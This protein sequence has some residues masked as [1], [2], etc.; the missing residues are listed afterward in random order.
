MARAGKRARE[1]ELEWKPTRAVEEPILNGPYDEPSRHWVYE[2]DDAGVAT[3][4]ERSG[5]RPASYFSATLAR[6][7]EQL[8]SLEL[9]NRLREDVGRW[10]RSGYRGASR[11]TRELFRHWFDPS[12]TPRLFFCQREAVETIVYLLELA[13]PGR[14]AA[15]GR[16]DPRVDAP[17]L[18]RLLRGEPPGLSAATED[19]PV[20]LVDLPGDP[21]M[22]PLTRLGLR[23]ATGTG[24]TVVMAMIITWAFCNRVAEPSNTHFPNAVLV[25]APNLTVKSRL[26]VLRPEHPQSDYQR[27]DL[28]PAKYATSLQQ[29]RVLVTNW[30]AFTPRS[31]HREGDRTYRVV[32]KGEEPGDAFVKSGRLGELASRLPILV[33]NDEGHHCWR[34]KGGKI[35]DEGSREDEVE[36]AR[37]WLAGLDRINNAGLL[38]DAGGEPRRCILA[39]I[40]LSATPFYL[41][42]SGYLEGSPFPWLVTSFGLIDAIES[43]IVKIPRLPEQPRPWQRQEAADEAVRALARRWK[44]RFDAHEH[45]AAPPVMIIVCDN[46]ELADRVFQRVSGER[47][48]EVVDPQGKVK[49]A[50]FFEGSEVLAELAN[51]E[52]E[53]R[54]VRIDSRLLDKLERAEGE[55]RDE[56]ALA[57]RAI[58]DTVGKPGQPGEHIRCV[59]SVSMLTEGWDANN[60]THIL[61][62]RAFGSQLLCEQVVGRGL[63]RRSYELGADGK[64]PAEYVDVHGIPFSSIPFKGEGMADRASDGPRHQMFA[65]P[66]RA[67]LEIRMPAV[68]GYVHDIRDGGIRCDV[69]RLAPLTVHRCEAREGDH[70]AARLQQVVF[71][72][73]RRIVDDLIDGNLLARHLVFPAVSRILTEYIDRRVSFAAGV[74]R[75]ALGQEPYAS[76]LRERVRAGI[77]V[78]PTAIEGTLLPIVNRLAEYHTTAGVDGVTD[79]PVRP[80]ARCHLNAVVIRGPGDDAVIDVLE[81]AEDVEAFAPGG[82][83][84]GFGIVFDH[85]GESQRYAPD[86]IVRLRGGTHVMLEIEREGDPELAVVRRNAAQRWVVAVNNRRRY[87]A[88]AFETVYELAALRPTLRKHAAADESTPRCAGCGGAHTPGE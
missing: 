74:D 51:H 25:C 49:K 47:V 38:N 77:L 39:A 13:I 61:G 43:G 15:T 27:F 86:F 63:R 52:G 54:T 76:L 18:A 70:E 79:R 87:G 71:R 45:G 55:S 4:I 67:R 78:S 85:L 41:A 10:R 62:L 65:V 56:A 75:R 17:L 73:A 3:P 11:V 66:G 24:K 19:N 42:A 53:R 64:L 81:A 58:I 32:D 46:I 82:P 23:M 84:G 88:W 7:P 14:L 28:V 60:V 21:A 2:M 5:R 40:D 34:A 9:P 36:E 33:L 59:V 50:V 26:Q 22:L 68:D 12:R 30:H 48:R 20:R 31:A 37:V 6:G 57:L 29:G 35:A 83:Q 69:D 8:D 44:R 72:V 80:V 16:H 1:A